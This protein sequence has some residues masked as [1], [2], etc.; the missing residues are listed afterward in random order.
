MPA[1][2]QTE[3]LPHLS[4]EVGRS[5]REG[6]RDAGLSQSTNIGEIRGKDEIT[7]KLGGIGNL[8][9]I[10]DWKSTAL[11]Q[12]VQPDG[13]VGRSNITSVVMQK[14]RYL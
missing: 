11:N 4:I 13:G 7:V 5:T 9:A 2:R 12:I 8:E 1:N 6:R 14:D 10:A 3:C